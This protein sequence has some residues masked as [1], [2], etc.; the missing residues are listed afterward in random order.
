[1]HVVGY[2]TFNSDF[3]NRYGMKFEEGKKYITNGPIKF[4]NDGNGF[5]MCKNIEDTFRY[6]DA[7][8]NDVKVCKV[9]GSGKIVNFSDEYYEYFDMYAVEQIEILKL[10]SRKEIID[11]ALDLSELRTQRFVSQFRLTKE[12]IELFNKKFF[13]CQN[14]LDAIEYYQNNNLEVYKKGLRKVY[15]QDY[16]KRR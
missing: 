6:Y 11:I 7:L 12:E 13:E 15:G 1:M 14:I 3:T 9:E 4:G 16:N 5:H 8:N 10:L 2:K